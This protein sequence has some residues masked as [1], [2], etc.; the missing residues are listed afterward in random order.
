MAVGVDARRQAGGT[1]QSAERRLWRKFRVVSERPHLAEIA[2][3]ATAQ[4]GPE[5]DMGRL[6]TGASPRAGPRR[7][8]PHHASC[9]A[10]CY[11]F[12]HRRLVATNMPILLS[13]MT[14]LRSPMEKLD[15]TAPPRI[16]V[17]SAGGNSYRIA[18][19]FGD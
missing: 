9:G 4:T 12:N 7:R 17:V 10:L 5:P 16:T 6:R 14:R 13:V 19:A 18:L 1:E 3:S 2:Q 8:S 11:V 15:P